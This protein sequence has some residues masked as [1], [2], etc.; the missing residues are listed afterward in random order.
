MSSQN[1]LNLWGQVVLTNFASFAANALSHPFSTVQT[2][3]QAVKDGNHSYETWYK[4]YRHVR[5]PRI[6]TL[7]LDHPLKVPSTSLYR[8]L[9][10]I[11]CVDSATFALA[12]ILNDICRK[13]LR[14][15][16]MGAIPVATAF[17]TLIV[18]PGEGAMQNRQ[19]NNL[20]YRDPELWRRTLRPWG[21]VATGIRDLFWNYGIFFV[22][23]RLTDLA[24][25]VAPTS[26]PEWSL[27]ISSSLVTGA[28]VGFITT[29]IAG[30]KTVILT[31]EEDLTIRQAVRRMA[32]QPSKSQVDGSFVRLMARVR[33]MWQP[34]SLPQQAN[35][36]KIPRMTERLF[37]GA[38]A[39]VT[40]ISLAMTGTHFVYQSLPRS[41]P[42]IFQADE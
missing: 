3:R 14:L 17:S 13:T 35:F 7:E 34:C 36:L 22:A 30:I 16:E 18:W 1:Q 39:R 9:G 2:W 8:G 20:S 33:Q 24:S 26:I 19:E 23:P 29:P 15:G 31:S 21:G 4:I 28:T 40:A 42:K 10:A 25:R 41:L 6:G 27:Q 32:Y 12:Y 11:Y 38:G 37:A 5:L